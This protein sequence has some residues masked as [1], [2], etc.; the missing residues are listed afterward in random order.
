[1]YCPPELFAQDGSDSQGL[2]RKGYDQRHWLLL[3]AK[4]N[5]LHCHLNV[6]SNQC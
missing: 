6:T 2:V 5:H 4:G 1:M 3:E